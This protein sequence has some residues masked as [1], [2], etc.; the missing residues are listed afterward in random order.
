M[1][2]QSGMEPEHDIANIGAELVGAS[3]STERSPGEV[4]N[5]LFPYVHEASRRMSTR[6]IRDWLKENYG[7]LISQPT[8]SR[9]LRNP[10]KYRQAFAEFIEPWARRVEEAIPPSM[11][12]F[13]FDDR[14]FKHFVDELPPANSFPQDS[15][16]AA[17]FAEVEEAVEFLEYRW[18]SLSEETRQQYRRYFV[19]MEEP[20]AETE[21]EA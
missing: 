8:L 4:L 17:Q 7:I 3:L 15:D 11:Q 10:E 14:L 16:E 5:E 19:Q 12:D 13:L 9:A 2:Y 1:V 18:F 20:D 21:G 6:G